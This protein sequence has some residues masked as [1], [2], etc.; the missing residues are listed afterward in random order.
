M[1]SAM[2]TKI[3]AIT[4]GSDGDLFVGGSFESRMWDG[5]KFIN[6]QHLARF[7]GILELLD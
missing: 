5:K 6:I 3:L 7:Y 1:A 4:L 2:T